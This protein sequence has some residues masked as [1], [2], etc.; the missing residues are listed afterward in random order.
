MLHALQ[1]WAAEEF[2]KC[3]AAYSILVDPAARRKYDQDVLEVSL[4]VH[5]PPWVISS[6]AL[7]SESMLQAI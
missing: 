1:E 5:M 3:S 4:H 6:A 7:C 2:K